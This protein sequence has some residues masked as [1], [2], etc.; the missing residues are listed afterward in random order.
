MISFPVAIVVAMV[1]SPKDYGI[2]GYIGVFTAWAGFISPG[3]FSAVQR[4]LPGL[5]ESRKFSEALYLQNV[6]VTVEVLVTIVVTGAL[7]VFVFFQQDPL[8]RSLML[9]LFLGFALGRFLNYLTGINFAYKQFSLSAKARFLRTILYPVLT[10]SMI[11]WMK[12]YT[13]PTV[14]L[15]L[16]V[17][18]IIYL[19]YKMEYG[20]RFIFDR[21]QTIRLFRIGIVMVAGDILFVLFTSLVDKTLIAAFLSKEAL[22]LWVFSQSILLIFLEIFKDYARVLKPVIWSYASNV[23]KTHMRFLSLIRMSVYFS[24]AAAIITGFAQSGFIF[25]VNYI[26]VKFVEAQFVFLFLS[27]YIF[28]EASEM[29]PEIILYS[30][31]ANRQNT[32]IWIWGVGVLI[33]L[34]LDFIVIKL[35]YGIVGVAIATVASQVFSTTLMN[36]KASIY[37]FEHKREFITH[38]IKITAPFLIALAFSLIHWIT[39][40][41]LNIKLPYIL[42]GSVLIQFMIWY[43]FISIFYK[44]YMKLLSIRTYLSLLRKTE[45]S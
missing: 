28:W 10:L 2:L 39:L 43:L 24:L 11:F 1:L 38:F 9:I 20:I 35:G 8:M 23:E 13:P 4:E 45:K 33:N 22:G 36:I 17:I 37:L 19:F 41:H 3:I 27:L 7:M 44:N 31:S 15:V 6:A 21:G 30:K 26:T 29:F 14:N 40:K 5:K 42:V 34:I 25:L 18:I 12:I 16:T 32:V